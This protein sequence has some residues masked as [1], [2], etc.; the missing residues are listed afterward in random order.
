MVKGK[1]PS[2]KAL[3]DEVLSKVNCRL[4]L[5][6]NAPELIHG[7]KMVKA[8]LTRDGETLSTE[9]LLPR[10]VVDSIDNLETQMNDDELKK[11]LFNRIF[12]EYDACQLYKCHVASN[13]CKTLGMTEEAME[14]NSE[15]S[16]Y[17][18]RVIERASKLERM[19]TS[20]EL[21]KIKRYLYKS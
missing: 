10:E 5:K 3:A 6:A 2:C 21:R 14:A 19:F 12:K 8:E 20:E 4:T 16:L 1:D 13:L 9:I 11:A 17:A 15:A 7:H 18:L